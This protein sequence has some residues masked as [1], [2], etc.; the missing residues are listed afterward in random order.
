MQMTN[1]LSLSQMIRQPNEIDEQILRQSLQ[2][3][4]GIDQ[5]CSINSQRP[6]VYNNMDLN[7]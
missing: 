6:F 2:N 1:S 3:V 7:S 4:S 5:L